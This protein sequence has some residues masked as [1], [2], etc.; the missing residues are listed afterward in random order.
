MAPNPAPAGD[1][2]QVPPAAGD[3]PPAPKPEN[4]ETPEQLKAKLEES[5]R[6]L[7]AANKEAA[8]RRKRL[9]ELEK[10]EADRQAASLSE[11]EKLQK[12]LADANAKAAQA[13]TQANERLIRAEIVAKAAVMKFADPADAYALIDRSKITVND[14]GEIEGADELL[15]DLA[16]AKPYMLA[17]AAP[18]ALNTGNPPGGGGEGETD[19]QKS[20]R[21]Y[22]SGGT[23][24]D[25]AANR[26][27]GG[28][29]YFNPE[30][31]S[32]Q[33]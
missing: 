25:A 29:A 10:A 12:Q 13:Q 2:P 8:D 21:I 11:T 16:K 4:T 22:G 17:K 1:P 32:K 31:N 15:K 19:A 30:L 14:A 5:Q 26:A 27:Q 6:A 23:Y 33:T 18:G 20:A 24:F 9:E 7:K 28:G 3:P